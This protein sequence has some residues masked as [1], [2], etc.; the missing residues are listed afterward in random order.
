MGRGGCPTDF[1]DAD[2][3]F[4]KDES[5]LKLRVRRRVRATCRAPPSDRVGR[6]AVVYLRE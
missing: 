3:V 4:T 1:P 6:L 5:A 2:P